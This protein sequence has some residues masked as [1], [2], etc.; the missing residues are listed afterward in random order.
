[1]YKFFPPK[2]KSLSNVFK[3]LTLSLQAASLFPCSSSLFLFLSLLRQTK[4]YPSLVFSSVSLKFCFF[5][6][7]VAFYLLG[8]VPV[9]FRVQWSLVQE[10][11]VALVPICSLRECEKPF[12]PSRKSWGIILMLIS[13][14]PSRKPTWILT[15]PLRNCSTKVGGCLGGAMFYLYVLQ[16][17]FPLLGFLIVLL[18]IFLVFLIDEVLVLA[19]ISTVSFF[20]A[21][22]FV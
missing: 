22:V 11:R 21:G 3:T 16:S 10:R 20:G 8:W 4:P 13:M 12:N 5:V 15:K 9:G 2:L 6:V 14:M 19:L 17:S 7:V 1:V 18:Y